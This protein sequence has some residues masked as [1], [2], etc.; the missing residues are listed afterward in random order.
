MKKGLIITV[1]TIIA[2]GFV[3][4]EKPDYREKWVGDWEFSTR[5]EYWEFDVGVL[6]DT[7]YY[8]LGKISRGN[9]SEQL[10]IT[11]MENCSMDL[12]VDE[13][14]KILKFSGEGINNAIRKANGQFEEI[15]N[16]YIYLE[17][18]GMGGGSKYTIN[19]TKK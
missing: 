3:S 14:G 8:Y 5:S 4:C 12:S 6:R 11:Y 1:L 7:T 10:N 17:L 2:I 19:G 13:N 16:I 15:D 9:A 18:G